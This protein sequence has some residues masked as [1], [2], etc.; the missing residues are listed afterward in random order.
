[1]RSD[2]DDRGVIQ[3]GT[4]QCLCFYLQLSALINL[5]KL[6]VSYNR[7][8]TL[9][10]YLQQFTRLSVLNLEGTLEYLQTPPKNVASEGISAIMNYFNDLFMGEPSWRIKLMIVGQGIK[11]G[12]RRRRE[13]G[14]DRRQ[15][16]LTLLAGRVGK[17]SILKCLRT[18]KKLTK[19]DFPSTAQHTDVSVS[20]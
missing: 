16:R 5:T 8:T 15:Y 1:M 18:G 20:I 14:G 2:G 17:T 10:L 3:Y 12:A 7:I 11:G 19:N 4:N 13:R 9:P 6:D